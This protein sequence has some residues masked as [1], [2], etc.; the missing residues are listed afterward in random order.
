MLICGRLQ[1][2]SP[3]PNI[4]M[5]LVPLV[6]YLKLLYK[7]SIVAVTIVFVLIRMTLYQ[8]LEGH[9]MRTLPEVT[10]N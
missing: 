7:V 1:E 10:P 8:W 2:P 5:R 4:C 6:I 3:P 9:I